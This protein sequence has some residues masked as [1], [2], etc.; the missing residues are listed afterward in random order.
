M[1]PFWVHSGLALLDADEHG[2][3]Q[4]TDAF[5]RAY[6]ERPELAPVD[7]SCDAE[8]A[9]HASLLAAPRRPVATGDRGEGGELAA[10]A[11][12]DA[13]ENWRLFLRFRDRLLAAPNL[14]SAYVAIFA[15]AQHAGRIDVPPLF[16]EQLAQII[17]HHILADSED[18]LLLRVAE[19][20]FREQR[21]S[22]IDQR[23]VLA[24]LE[25]VEA[26][27]RDPGLG[28]LGRL[29][30]QA[31]VKTRAG[32]GEVD[33]E[34]IDRANAAAYFGRD[35]RHDFAVEITHGRVASAMLCDLVRR[36]VGHLLGVPVRVATLAAID[37]VRWRWHV[38]LDAQASLL[39]D[40][41]Y[42][43]EGLAPDEHRRILLLMRLDFERL[44][45]QDPA[46]AGKPVYLALAADE[47]G[48]LRMKPQNLL[49]NL[50]LRGH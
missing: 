20:W 36:W 48:V 12:A 3:L 35:E 44:E 34:V 6:L 7:E 50:P 23:V 39:L 16:V 5:L 29:L 24:D 43:E 38:G 25:T 1:K 40:K 37:D 41:L 47:A 10:L 27:N 31:N 14:Q 8:R 30:A 32:A 13:R 26:R 11:D 28:N 46:V 33:L 49:F 4:V 21:V 15:D 2:G 18:G 9:L 17:V 22:L 45:D 42:R 19:L